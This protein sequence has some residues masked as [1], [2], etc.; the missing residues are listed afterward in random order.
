MSDRFESDRCFNQTRTSFETSLLGLSNF[1][2]ES[3]VAQQSRRDKLRVQHHS[4]PSLTEPDFPTHL[5]QL[6]PD[7]IQVRNVRS[8]DPLYDPAMFSSLG[9]LNYSMNSHG[10]LAHRDAMLQQEASVDRTGRLVGTDDAPFVSHPVHSEFN[11][12]AKASEVNNAGYWKGFGS[13]QN[14]DWIVNYSFVG[15]ILSGT[16]EY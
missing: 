2:P 10:L 9:M 1:R 7:L 12:P 16:K 3:H 14:C 13:Q 4:N 8:C 11:P 6:S 5:V 15:G